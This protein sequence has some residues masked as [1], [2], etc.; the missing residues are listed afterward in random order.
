[1]KTVIL[2]G[3]LGTRLA[4]ETET[5]PKP[6]VEIGDR[7][8]VW[9]IMKHFQQAGVH[10]FLLAVGYL[11]DQIERYFRD[12]REDWTVDVVD[13]GA[14]TD[15]GGRLLRLAPQLQDGPFF[16]TYGDGLADLDLAA[17]RSLHESH[18]KL[19]TVTAVRPPSRYGELIFQEG[20]EVR[21]TEKPQL[22]EGWINGGFMV[23]D[24]AVFDVIGGDETS[25]EYDVLEP[26][27]EKGQVVAYRHSGFW[28]CMDTPRDL[29]SLRDLWAAGPPPWASWAR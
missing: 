4:E 5:R 2:A 11:G 19:A 28:R 20:D 16:L 12:D 22:E 1:M 3:G 25:L 15:T 14:R 29:R 24:P 9:H 17:L 26:L 27:S 7:P 13:T 8:I 18:G 23:L 6:M 10:D 21:F